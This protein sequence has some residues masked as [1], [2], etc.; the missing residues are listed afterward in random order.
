MNIVPAATDAAIMAA[1]RRRKSKIERPLLYPPEPLAT[2]IRGAFPF[3]A[4]LDSAGTSMMV[5]SF[6]IFLETD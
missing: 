2:P 1:K 3:I 5:D 6:F 4:E